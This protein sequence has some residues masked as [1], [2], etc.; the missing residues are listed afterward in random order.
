MNAVL[1]LLRVDRRVWFVARVNV[2]MLK[3]PDDPTAWAGWS[4]RGLDGK[5]LKGHPDIYACVLG[6]LVYIETKGSRGTLSD[7]QKKFKEMC[8]VRGIPYLK[9][10]DV[11]ALKGWIDELEEDWCGVPAETRSLA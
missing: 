7:N 3:R 4:V 2:G 6:R 5:S 9:C 8:D 11:M 1:H 10:K